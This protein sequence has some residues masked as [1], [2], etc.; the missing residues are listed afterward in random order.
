MMDE[1]KDAR[2]RIEALE[3]ELSGLRVPEGERRAGKSVVFMLFGCIALALL[4]AFGIWAAAR[5]PW[6]PKKLP[7]PPPASAVVD[8][9]GRGVVLALQRCVSQV[10]ETEPIDIKLRVKVSA[11][12]SVGVVEA[13]VHPLSEVLVPCARQSA[14]GLR[15]GQTARDFDLLVTYEATSE[16]KFRRMARWNWVTVEMVK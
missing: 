6:A 3:R 7:P 10:P 8:E 2:A 13:N 16:P 14:S 9:T 15:P 11:D 4:T 12:G 1:L 5:K